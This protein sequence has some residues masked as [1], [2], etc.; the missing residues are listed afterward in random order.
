MAV[1]QLSKRHPNRLS[2]ATAGVL[3]IALLMALTLPPAGNVEEKDKHVMARIQ[4][5][6][7]TFLACDVHRQAHRHVTDWMALRIH[8]LTMKSIHRCQS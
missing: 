8:L 2:L 1:V 7:S 6:P 3:R 4:N 5:G